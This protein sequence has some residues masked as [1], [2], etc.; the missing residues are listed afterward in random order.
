MLSLFLAFLK[1]GAFGFGSGPAMLALIEKEMVGRGLMAPQ[2][3]TDAVA[4]GMVLPGPIATKTSLFCG[5][6]VAGV[7]GALV[8]LT[9]MLLPSTLAMLLLVKLM[10]QYRGNPKLESALRAIKPVVVAIFIFL[11]VGATR[12]IRPGWDSI[13]LGGVAL[14]LLLLKVDPAWVI[15]GALGI[16]LLFY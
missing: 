15:I 9:G 7:P 2:E 16:G 10:S 12:G 4:A 6:H 13:L 1:V 8:A 14:T 3:F 5:Y 11:A